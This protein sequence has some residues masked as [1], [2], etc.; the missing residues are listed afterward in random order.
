M[1]SSEEHKDAHYEGGKRSGFLN[2]LVI[3][4]VARGKYPLISDDGYG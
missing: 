3:W 4:K 2:A 1:N